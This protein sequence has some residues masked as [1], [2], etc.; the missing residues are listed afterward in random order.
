[1][2]KWINVLIGLAAML[3]VLPAARAQEIAERV[4]IEAIPSP[5]NIVLRRPSDETD[6][7]LKISGCPTLRAGQTL[8][9][10]VRGSLNGNNDRLDLG[11]GRR[12]EIKNVYRF[13]QKLPVLDT[14]RNL[15]TVQFSNGEKKRLTIALDCGSFTNAQMT[16]LYLFRYGKSV[17]K[18][19]SVL[20]PGDPKTCPITHV[21][22]FED[23]KISPPATHD[24]DIQKPTD[25]TRVRAIPK[26]GGAFVYWLPAKDDTGVDHYL[27]SVS[28][29][30]YDRKKLEIASA[31][32]QRKVKGTHTTLSDLRP[33]KDY[34]FYV[35]AVDAAGNT[36]SF[37]SEPAAARTSSALS[38]VADKP[39]TPA[40]LF[41]R[42]RNESAAEF[43][44]GWQKPAGGTH[45]LV[46]L[47]ADGKNTMSKTEY[48]KTYLRI[49]KTP[50]LKGKK[51]VLQISA[52]DA[53]GLLEQEEFL[54][55]F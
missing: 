11:L 38:P 52:F 43:L 36:G 8:Q 17:A 5:L 23:E 1:M 51:L 32:D 14:S 30:R 35:L 21:Q 6:Y 4:T 44:I 33:D 27:V 9:L 25:V 37:W 12:C 47:K 19:D 42:V 29:A 16:E 54:F 28:T 18:G 31:P 49:A 34:Y 45:F 26:N 41:I 48:S 7:L 53:R 39:V 15:A 50:E 3:S 24:L 10:I 40:K 55:E 22:E 20:I 46:T 13:N 2:K